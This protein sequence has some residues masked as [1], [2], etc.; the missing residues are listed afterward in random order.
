MDRQPQVIRSVAN[1]GPL[2][3]AIQNRLQGTG[4]ALE[5][6]RSQGP[7]KDRALFERAKVIV[8]PHGGGFA[9]MIFARPGTHIIEFLPIYRLYREGRG[10]RPVFWGMA[11]ACGLDYWTSEPD[12]FGF[13]Q[14]GMQVDIDDVVEILG[15]VIDS[16]EG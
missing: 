1:R 9:N 15:R 11:Q 6:F 16:G 2:L 12:E 14:R 4:Y 7:T 13:D 10:P 5:I 3:E 8:G